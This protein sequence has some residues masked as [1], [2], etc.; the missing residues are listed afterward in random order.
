V[1]L[2]VYF[3]SL[4]KASSHMVGLKRFSLEIKV[5]LFHH[6]LKTVLTSLSLLHQLRTHFNLEQFKNPR[7]PYL[8]AT[9]MPE[10]M[11]ENKYLSVRKKV[12]SAFRHK[13]YMLMLDFK[14]R[15]K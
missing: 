12:L 3:Y 5:A 6:V 11:V 14:E 4:V 9:Y 10:N 2:E 13:I 7:I 1:V 8:S 15:Q